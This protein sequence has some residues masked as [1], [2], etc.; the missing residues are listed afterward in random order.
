MATYDP[1]RSRSRPRAADPEAPAPVD[2]LL[3]PAEDAVPVEDG[4]T[5]ERAA[6][7]PLVIDLDA[8]APAGAASR[9]GAAARA[10]VV[11]VVAALL[12][13]LAW[14]WYRRRA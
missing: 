6:R 11:A 12:A 9:R 1:Q 7:E 3:G 4:A 2:A 14:L 10:A 13:A 5:E 8:P